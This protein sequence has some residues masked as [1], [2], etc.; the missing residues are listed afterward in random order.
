[1]A[2]GVWRLAC[3]VW[4]VVCC[5]WCVVAA[6]TFGAR[7]NCLQANDAFTGLFPGFLH[8]MRHPDNFFQKSTKHLLM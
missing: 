5:A 7:S 8:M 4:G 2:S 3:A 1:M 6:L